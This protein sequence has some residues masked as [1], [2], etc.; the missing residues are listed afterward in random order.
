MTILSEFNVTCRSG[1]CL[2]LADFAVLA[3][4]DL[5]IITAELIPLN[6]LGDRDK[7][8]LKF[9]DQLNDFGDRNISFIKFQDR[10]ISMIERKLSSGPQLVLR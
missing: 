2:I 5:L 9:Q 4:H 10:V 7:S 1:Q 3:L 8:F 6:G